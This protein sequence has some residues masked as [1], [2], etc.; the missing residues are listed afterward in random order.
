M[1]IKKY[2]FVGNAHIAPVWMWR[3]QDGS[4]EAKA[5]IRS[6]LD[7]I[8][9]YP[10]F[11][12]V[13]A[14]SQ[15]FEWIEEFDPEMFEEIRRRV[16]EGR[17]VITGG[18]FIQPDCNLPCGEGFVRQGL[19]GQRYF[20]D[21]FGVTAKTGYNVD[22]FGHNAMLP[23]ILKKSG[24]EQY[25]ALRPGPHEKTLPSHVVRWEAPD[26]SQIL[27]GRI[28]RRYA[29]THVN[30][31]DEAHL[32]AMMQEVED[33]ASPDCASAFFFYGVGNH[34][35]GPTKKNIE[36]ILASRALHP[37][38]EY[39][40]SDTED[41][42][43]DIRENYPNLP[44]VK[45]DLQHHASGCYSTVSSN[46]DCIRRAEWGMFAA[47]NFAMLANRLM[48]KKM[49]A[50]AEFAKAWKN[51][52]FAHFHDAMGGCS[53][54]VVY[55]DLD[56]MLKEARA[57]AQRAENNALQSLSWKID[58]SDAE[59]GTPIILFNPHG[60][61]V[62]TTVNVI[63]RL[64]HI[65]DDAGNEVPSQLVH[66]DDNRCRRNAGHTLFRA[67]IPA[68][69][70]CTYYHT[71][72]R[73][74]LTALCPEEE[75]DPG[76]F[77]ESPVKAEGC[78]LENEALRV[79]F[80]SHT[81][82]IQSLYDKKQEKELLK[83]FGAVPVVID[84]TGYD[85]W[86]HG[87]FYFD[88]EI[89]RFAD[90]Q[91]KVMES[92]PVRARIKVVS[93]YNDS[94]LTQYF[95]LHA[96][97]KEL[98]TEAYIDW[99]EKH[100]M[101]KLRFDTA[102]TEDPHAFYEIPY[103][104]FERPAD[105]EEEPG[106]SW[107]AVKEN[108]CGLALLNN[109]KYSFSIRGNQMNLTVVRSPFYNDHGAGYNDPEE[110]CRYMDQGVNRFCYQLLPVNGNGWGAV[111][112]TARLLN[113]P[114]TMIVE[115]KHPGSLPTYAQGL[116]CS[117]GNV[118]VSAWKRSEDGSGMILRAYE[119]DGVQTEASFS[120]MVLPVPLTAVFTPY[121]IQTYF[122]RDGAQ[123]WTEVMLTEFDYPSAE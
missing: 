11:K 32:Q 52:L 73:A 43:R 10:E 101:L 48:G 106:Q 34:G 92:G 2:Y 57:F 90:A 50:T 105:G 109:N 45:D 81:G 1:K 93:R 36:S 120:G 74:S 51:I 91:V 94:V 115:N 49:P 33:A 97:G 14:A 3:W 24:M 79:T 23:Q 87:K 102:F 122:L 62:E 41:F 7:R 85:T 113:L 63:H 78:V 53:A 110:E 4:A 18:W 29:T 64:K 88:N 37:E 19:Y 70:Y 21:K 121:S 31:D 107:I 42:F 116:R 82:Y 61:D 119:T 38:V 58:T 44:V 68:L 25:V 27:F 75:A 56:I 72:K 80:Q 20:Y 69:G 112:K 123:E 16:R 100:K 76:T 95:T 39:I 118:I 9:E 13:C 111:I 65:Y 6:A 15:V 67:K 83:G 96:G 46:K 77:F 104:V 28:L 84:E 60:F 17:F 117:V 30:I 86:A 5:T 40:M 26:G 35:G 108:G 114:P 98:E 22:S 47:E 89:A 55:D 66:G 99:R 103:G 8:R 54:P 71:S 59:K 12:F